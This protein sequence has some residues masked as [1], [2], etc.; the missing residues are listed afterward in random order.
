[1]VCDFVGTIWKW[2][3][4]HSL[5]WLFCNCSVHQNQSLHLALFYVN[6]ASAD[7]LIGIYLLTIASADIHT[8]DHFSKDDVEWRTGPGCGFAGFCAIT[9]TMISVYTLVVISFERFFVLVIGMQW[10]K[11]KITLKAVV[12]IAFGWLFGIVIGMLPLFGISSYDTV[13]FCLPFDISTTPALIYVVSLLVLTGLTFVVIAIVY[14]SYTITCIQILSFSKKYRRLQTT[15][16]EESALTIRV[17]LIIITN[18][19]C[20]FPIALVGLTAV[21]GA[22]LNGISVGNAK[23]FVVLVFSLNACLNPILYSFSTVSFWKK[24]KLCLSY[25]FI[26]KQNACNVQGQEEQQQTT[27]STLNPLLL[28]TSTESAEMKEKV[29]QL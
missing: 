1:M 8:L 24:I 11:S 14:N 29:G 13:P 25:P 7:L 27:I 20:W 22:P 10:K 28:T 19:N 26:N 2:D 9:S 21:F 18:L 17:L 3:G 23:I 4:Y 12:T 16:K 15:K 5:H 6:L